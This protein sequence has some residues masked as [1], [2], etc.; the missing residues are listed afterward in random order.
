VI[1]ESSPGRS[2]LLQ[3]GTAS[4]VTASRIRWVDNITVWLVV[5]AEH[6]REFATIL[7]RVPTEIS[8]Y[9][10]S[11]DFTGLELNCSIRNFEKTQCTVLKLNRLT[12]CG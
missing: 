4:V 11:L 9:C 1:V 12:Y 7:F 10:R 5:L 8:V 6:K 3:R 2:R